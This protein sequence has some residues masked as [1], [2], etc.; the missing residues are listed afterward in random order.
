MFHRDFS[1]PECN[2]PMSHSF[3]CKNQDFDGPFE[4]LWA[5][6]KNDGPKKP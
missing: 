5:I 6:W 2:G 3:A 1:G 4:F